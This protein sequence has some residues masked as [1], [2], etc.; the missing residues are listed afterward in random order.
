[1]NRKMT[2][3]V[4]TLC[5][6]IVRVVGKAEAEWR[7][8]KQPSKTERW[9]EVLVEIERLEGEGVPFGV[10]ETSRMNK[11]VHHFLSG[12]SP[13]K[14]IKPR[15]VRKLLEKTRILRELSAHSVETDRWLAERR[16][17]R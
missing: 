2:P 12:Q 3:E 9:H 4:Y 1:M 7:E 17:G 14:G 6:A 8:R 15:S 10:C 16:R 11:A 13:A 5:R